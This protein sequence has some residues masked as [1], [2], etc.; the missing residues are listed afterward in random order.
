MVM[1][2]RRQCLSFAGAAFAATTVPCVARAQTWPARPVRAIVGFPPGGTTD[3]FARLTTQKLSEHFGKQFYVENIGGAGGN[4]G[5]GQAA[6]AAADGHTILFPFNSHVVKPTLFA[7]VPYDPIKDFD[8]V[9]LAVTSPSVLTV[10]PSVPATTVN[11][12]VALIRANP[13]KY[14]FAVPGSGTPA[15]LT[16]EMFRLSLDLDLV[17]VPY[18]GAGPAVTSVIAGHSPMI[19][20]TL[21]AILQQV[22]DGKLRALSITSKMRSPMLPNVPTMIESGYPEIEGESWV[23]LLTPAGT[24]KEIVAALHRETTRIITLPEMKERFAALGF[25]VVA[26]TPPDFGERLQAELAMWAKVVRVAKIK[27][28]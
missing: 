16:A 15:H 7:K 12:L 21:A 20:T 28:E 10:N 8:P 1:L 14:N 4:I 26:S 18:N 19:F 13:G 6:R 24:P 9:T 3:I 11:E 22:N 23:G 17:R 25:D 27:I 5:T 2:T